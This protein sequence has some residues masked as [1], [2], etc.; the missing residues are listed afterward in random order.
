MKPIKLYRPSNGSEGDWFI[1]KFCAN[2]IHGKYEHT[3][4]VNDKPCKIC[5][6]S[7]AFDTKDKEYPKEWVYDENDK[8][9]CTAFVKWDWGKDDNGNW[10]DPPPI[11]PDD[12][13]QLCLP[14]MIEE[15]NQNTQENKKQLVN[16]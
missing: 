16:F 2:C 1:D 10:N 11:I 8:P 7:M 9:I 6:F 14:F 3:G 12:P 15:I 5:S 4:D 13:D